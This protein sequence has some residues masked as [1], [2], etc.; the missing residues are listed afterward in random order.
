VAELNVDVGMTLR[1]RIGV[2]TGEVVVGDPDIGGALV[3]VTRSTSP[4]GWS[5]RPRQGRSCWGRR[6]GG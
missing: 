1:I 5:R 3:L 2:N 6:P 4:L